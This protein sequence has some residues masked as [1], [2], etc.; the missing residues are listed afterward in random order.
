MLEPDSRAMQH[1]EPEREAPLRA[2]DFLRTHRAAVLAEWEHAMHSGEPRSSSWLLDH[3]PGLLGALA[4]AVDQGPPDI[5][6]TLSDEHAAMRLDQGFDIGDVVAEYALLRQCI[7]RQLEAEPRGLAAGE[8][9]RLE[10]VLDR[11]VVQTVRRFAQGRQR[12]LQALDRMSQAALDSPTVDLILVR[13]LTIVMES[14]LSVDA[15]AVLMVEGDRLVVRAAVGLGTREALGDSVRLDEGFVGEVATRREPLTLRSAS[16]DARVALPALRESGLLAVHGVPL[17]EAGGRLLGVAY[18]GSHTSY[19]FTDEDM[20]L[21][22]A[23]CQRATVHLT[24]ARLRAAER[25][26]REEAQRSLALLDAL[27]AAT[28]VGIAFFDRDLRYLRINQTLAD[29][30]GFPPEEHVGRTFREMQPDEIADLVEPLLHRALT[31]VEPLQAFEFSTPPAMVPLR[32]KSTWQATFFPVRTPGD[33][34]LGLGCTLV[35]ITAHKQAEAALQH[36]VDFREQLLAVLGHDLRNP[37]NAIGASAFQLSRAQDLEPAEQ[38]AVERIRKSAGRMGRMITDILDFAR[39]KLGQGIPISP[40][41]MNMAEV[42]QAALEELQV[43]YPHRK[44]SFDAVG[45]TTG[46]WD[47]DRVSQVLGNLVTN[48]LHHGDADS[49]VRTTVRGEVKDVVLEVH[50]HGE[51]IPDE[52][53]PRIFDPFKTPSTLSTSTAPYKLQRS[54]GL[55]LYIVHQIARAHGGHVEVESNAREGTCFR[56]YWPRE[57]RRLTRG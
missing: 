28:P 9:E 3:M 41:V 5:D 15:A 37:L 11:A 16:T 36:S 19:A 34:L 12:V 7:L 23:M 22:R 27:V 33:G 29:I 18:M 53:M 42:C 49:P 48:A 24:Q 13:L 2:S 8:L 14:V 32:G 47:P 39:S 10:E 26:A 56:V 44:L 55:G 17:L 35:N 4:D 31:A 21:F 54:L 50:N 25:D 45:D 57:T 46:D 1:D 43:A 40:Q 6:N 52:L 51:P 30:N 38:R 20:L